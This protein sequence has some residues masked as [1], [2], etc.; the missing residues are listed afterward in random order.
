VG[1]AQATHRARAE[2]KTQNEMAT[3]NRQHDLELRELEA[4]RFSAQ[5]ARSITTL[6]VRRKTVNRTYSERIKSLRAIIS[7]IQQK[8][9]M[10]QLKIEGM[11]CIDIAPELKR[12]VYDP[13]SDLT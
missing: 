2:T 10:G 1:E 9:Q 8:D 5:A 13:V 6:E 7:M 12:L 3:A 11:D 4:L